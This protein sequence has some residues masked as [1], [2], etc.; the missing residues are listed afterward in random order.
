VGR[1]NLYRV[2]KTEFSN[3]KHPGTRSAHHSSRRGAPPVR[4]STRAPIAHGAAAVNPLSRAR[5][6]GPDPLGLG[7]AG[8]SLVSIAVSHQGPKRDVIARVTPLH[9]GVLGE[10]VGEPA[11]NPTASSAWRY[12]ARLG[13]A[14]RLSGQA[15]SSAATDLTPPG[16]GGSAWHR[17]LALIRIVRLIVLAPEQAHIEPLHGG[18]RVRERCWGRAA[19]DQAQPAGETTG[20]A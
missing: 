13:T 2:R 18:P 10:P 3:P 15:G 6:R 11:A 5:R 1:G 4:P 7:L 19:A 9:P 20:G 12:P 16:G 8:V 14:S 17:P